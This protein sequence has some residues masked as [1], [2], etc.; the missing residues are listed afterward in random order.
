MKKS[1]FLIQLI[2]NLEKS[3]FNIL[4]DENGKQGFKIA[5]KTRPDIIVTSFN[6]NGLNGTD[7]CFMIKNSSKLASTPFILISNF[8][9]SQE[10]INAFRYGV[11]AIVPSTISQSELI[12]KIDSLILNHKLLMQRSL[13]NA[14]SLQGQLND[15]K[16]IEILQMLNMT[17]K[18]GILSIFFDY[19]DGQIVF[20]IG[21][22][23]FAI[24]GNLTGEKAIHKMLT[25]DHGSFTFEKDTGETEKNINKS[26]MQLILDCCQ[27]L[28]ESDFQLNID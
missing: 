2:E 7:L 25:Q 27:M 14:P 26:T 8:M 20:D 1:D 17:Q 19:G 10:R 22:I 21:E 15:F 11:D 16:L 23:T 9:N 3:S 12:A 6:L 24:F 4:T 5:Q 13:K 18:S 28:D